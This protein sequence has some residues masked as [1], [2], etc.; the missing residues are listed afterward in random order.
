MSAENRDVTG[1]N[2]QTVL[3]H[4]GSKPAEYHGAV[5]VP[6]HRMSTIV[7]NSYDEFEKVPNVPYSYGRAGTPTSA[8]FEEAIA[9]IEGAHRSVA[10][11]SGLSAILTSLIAFASAGDHILVTDNCY[12]PGRKTC[13]EVLRRFGVDVEYYPPMIGGEIKTLFR[14]NTRLVFM[15]APGSLTFEVQDIG[16]ITAAAKEAGIKTAIDNSWG[17]P[18]C[19]KPLALGIDVSVMSA[20]KY[21]SGH[22]DVM[23]GVVSANASSWNA[24]KRAALMMGLCGGS[25]ELYLGARGLRTLKPR[26]D[27]HREAALDIATWLSTHKAVKQVRHPAL[28]SCPGHK[29]WKKYYQGS[30]GTFGIILH[31]NRRENIARM[32]DGMALFSMGFSWGGFES[33]L[34]PEQPGHARSASPWTE[35]GFSLRIHIGLEDKD[36]LKADLDEGLERLAA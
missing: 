33:L 28:P 7:F 5:N 19:L 15:E 13:E 24:V 22:S 34:F 2:I 4:A 20:T 30:S 23:L 21:I 26:M 25:E 29:N 1:K 3:T 16:A 10:T 18:L 12:G 14:P 8:A 27:H 11:C 17:T 9:A 35:E 32:L 36:D 6:V 31:E